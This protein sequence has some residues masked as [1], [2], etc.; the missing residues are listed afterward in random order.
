[1]KSLALMGLTHR[2]QE[3]AAWLVDL[4][5]MTRETAEVGERAFGF[6]VKEIGDE[7]VL[8]ARNGE[9]YELRLGEKSIPTPAGSQSVALSGDASGFGDP[10]AFGNGRGGRRGRG[11][12]GFGQGG[13]GQSGFGQAGFGGQ[14]RRSFRSQ[15]GG[16]RGS[17]SASTS[18]PGLGSSSSY[19][20]NSGYSGNRGTRFGNNTSGVRSSTGFGGSMGGGRSFGGGSYGGSAS[21]TSQFA[22]GTGGS[23]SNPQTARRRGA[24]LTGDTPALPSPQTIA[25]PQTQRRT[26]SNSGSAFGQASTSGYGTNR[27][28][29]TRSG[30]SGSTF[31]GR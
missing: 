12:G 27:T 9:E 29:N 24:R 7:R 17:F 1:M 14:G 13:F 8:L 2:D 18:A 23:T 20:S 3:D 19:S 21:M 11:Q 16:G 31:Q 4:N 25:N 15:Y 5:S 30:A 26:G 10:G 28:G 6:T 22:A